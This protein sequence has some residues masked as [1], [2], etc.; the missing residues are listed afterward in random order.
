MVLVTGDHHATGFVAI[1]A[2]IKGNQ[3]LAFSHIYKDARARSDHGRSQRI[4]SRMNLGTRLRR[5]RMSMACLLSAR[6][7][8]E[9]FHRSHLSYVCITEV[10]EFMSARKAEVK[11]K[12]KVGRLSAAA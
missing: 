2:L 5:E 9:A 4:S 12:R 6:D 3:L 8:A 11:A 1:K 10:C 7:R